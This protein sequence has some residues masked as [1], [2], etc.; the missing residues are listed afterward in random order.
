LRWLIL[1]L[2]FIA[3]SCL[4]FTFQ[5]L[6]AV[7]P[8]AG[9][10]L[11]IGYARMGE[12]IG[13]YWLPGIV[14]ALPAGLLAVCF[15]AKRLAV[16]SL[17]ITGLGSFLL[18]ASDSYGMAVAAR[19]VAGLGSA[20]LSVLISKMVADWF[21]GRELATA[22]AILFDS[23][24]FGLAATVAALPWIAERSSWSDAIDATGVVC[25]VAALLMAVAYRAPP[26]GATPVAGAGPRPPLAYALRHESLL[27]SFAA[28]LWTTYNAGQIILLTY[29]PPAL[30]ATGLGLSAAAAI[31]S[32]V[33]WLST[34]SMPFGE[35]IADRSGRL[36]GTILVGSLGAALAGAALAVGHAPLLAS[37]LAGLFIGLPAGGLF[38]LP[39]R[40]SAPDRVGWS[41]GRFMTVYY[42]LL[43][44][45]QWA[46]G[47]VRAATSDATT[48]LFGCGLLL[49][50]GLGILPL[51]LLRG[52]PL[53][54]RPG[55]R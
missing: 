2:I 43:T 44:A 32:L 21:R 49:V 38:S 4:A 28:L 7:A 23:W 19:L 29:A 48:A 3:R 15:G 40:F 13:F 9:P 50:T 42:L 36:I 16:A 14:V 47:Y 26:Q 10:A 27:P 30:A 41:I 46:G 35:M 53:T 25:V 55:A 18:G 12:L 11:G 24:S 39:L 33:A 22:L 17:I 31:V 52:A 8:L 34:L 37:V 5:G 45:T 51:R 1:A 6:G 54:P 20:V